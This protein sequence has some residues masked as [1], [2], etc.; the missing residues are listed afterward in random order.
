[1]VKSAATEQIERPVAAAERSLRILDA[2]AAEHR[3]L[4]LSDLA[5]ATGLFKSVILRYMISFEK[6]SY[7]RRTADGRYQ[8]SVKALQLGRSFE[9]SLD[10]RDLI[11]TAM[12]QL[13]DSTGESV[14]FY[15]REG[16]NRI[17]VMGMDSPQSLRVYSKIG[18]LIPMDTT[19][20]SQ[21]LRAHEAGAPA[22][23]VE[24][25]SMARHSVGA[26]DPLTSSV[27]APV[28]DRNNALVG[29]I[30]VSGPTARFDAETP[31]TQEQI[32]SAARLL[33]TLLGHVPPPE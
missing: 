31:E 4:S 5:D 3:P 13:R 27:S 17:C 12:T 32:A 33:S 1:M 24:A 2:F 11:A 22:G 25:V 28:F 8:L 9:N 23:T 21:A 15:V 6:L 29:V 19:S 16:E 30:A 26:Y 18:V 14:Y 10:Q 7:V 20:I